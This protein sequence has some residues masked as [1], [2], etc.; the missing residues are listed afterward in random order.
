MLKAELRRLRE[1]DSNE[2]KK[3][4]LRQMIEEER[5]AAGFTPGG[6]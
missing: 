1:K 3:A 4:L 5:G 6:T 2:Q